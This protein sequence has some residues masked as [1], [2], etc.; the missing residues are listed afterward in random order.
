MTKSITIDELASI[1]KGEFDSI[2]DRFDSI[3][4]KMENGFKELRDSHERLELKVSNVAYRFEVN[5][6]QSQLSLLRQRVDSLEN[7]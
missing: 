1:I 7:K 6:L 2:G 3:E 4:T 5:D